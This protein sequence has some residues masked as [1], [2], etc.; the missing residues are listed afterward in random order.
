MRAGGHLVVVARSDIIPESS[1]LP[2]KHWQKLSDIQCCKVEEGSS[3]LGEVTGS[4]ILDSDRTW[5]AYVGDKKVPDTCDVLARFRSSPLTDDKLS[6][7]IKAIDNVV[8][9]PG[10]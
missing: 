6:D 2:P 8:L 9:C 3:G 7:T 4:V 10:N 1:L 5:N